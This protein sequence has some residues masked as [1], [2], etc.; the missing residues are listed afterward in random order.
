MDEEA[1][2]SLLSHLLT[3]VNDPLG[4]E[5]PRDPGDAFL[6]QE[7]RPA[8]PGENEWCMNEV[9]TVINADN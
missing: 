2:C 5:L 8:P 1:A 9:N 6:Q 3:C 7:R 4:M